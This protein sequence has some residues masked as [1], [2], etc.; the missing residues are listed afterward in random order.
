MMASA[1]T[2]DKFPIGKPAFNGGNKLR[3]D[4]AKI[5]NLKILSHNRVIDE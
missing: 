4:F 5:R 1:P 3:V 2:R